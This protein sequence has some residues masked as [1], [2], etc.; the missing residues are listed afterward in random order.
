MKSERNIISEECYQPPLRQ[1]WQGRATNDDLQSQYW[2]QNVSLV[3]FDDLQKS[4]QEQRT[5]VAL[6]GYSC[7]EGVK[8]NLGRTGASKGPEKLRH[9]LAKIPFHNNTKLVLDIGNILCNS[10]N[11]E[12]CQSELAKAVTVLILNNIFP[13]IIGGGHDIAYG[14]FNG[15]LNTFKN[16]PTPK[17]G[18][19]N[20]DAHFD[21]R[22]AGDKPNSGTAFNQ[23]LNEQKGLVE[24]LVLGVQEQSN[25]KE[26]FDIAAKHQV[27]YFL[28]YDCVLSNFEK[29]R[30]GL[31]SFIERNDWIYITID[32]DGFSSAYAPGVSAPSPMGFTPY[33]VLQTLEYLFASKKVI[34]LDIA[35]LNPIYDRDNATANLAARLVDYV[36]SQI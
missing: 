27:N 15:I 20:F 34:S 18:I 16:C 24:Y 3:N 35:E 6:L 10:E 36:V 17:I 31:N 13:L 29:V 19:I 1:N 23:I 4:L 28:N 21:L 25:T 11:M 30:I 5:S 8:R 2:H 12:R 32:M 33:F 26:L 22:P 14:N 9:H 7:D